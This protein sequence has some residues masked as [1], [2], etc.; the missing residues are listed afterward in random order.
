MRR[1][2]DVGD[3]AVSTSDMSD[4]VERGNKAPSMATQSLA[5][6][7]GMPISTLDEPLSTSEAPPDPS[8]PEYTIED[9]KRVLRQVDLWILPVLCL[10]YMVQQLCKGALPMASAFDLRTL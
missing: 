5:S 7:Q 1:R 2:L 10:V 9:E 4:T 6:L 8:V 3:P